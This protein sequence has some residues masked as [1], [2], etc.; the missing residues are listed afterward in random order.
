MNERLT[1]GLHDELWIKG[2]RALINI[3]VQLNN[4]NV[5]ARN[6]NALACSK[7]LYSI[8]EVTLHDYKK[9]LG[10]ILTASGYTYK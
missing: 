3:E 7:E 5:I 10:D 8:G 6:A 1:N 2:A 4:A 9:L